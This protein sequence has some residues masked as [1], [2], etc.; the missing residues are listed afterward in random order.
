MA[1]IRNIDRDLKTQI[2]VASTL[3]AMFRLRTEHEEEERLWMSINEVNER[4]KDVL[5]IVGLML[6]VAVVL[7]PIL[8][9]R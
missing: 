4:R 6:Y 5:S 3:A 1:T 2:D 8:I 9:V 7:W